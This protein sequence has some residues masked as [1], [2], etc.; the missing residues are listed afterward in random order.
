[1]TVQT[2]Y[3]YIAPAVAGQIVDMYFNEIVS[4]LVEDA[5]GLEFGIAV[6]RGTGDNQVLVA[7][8]FG[9]SVREL[10]REM[11]KRGAG[12]VTKYIEGNS[13]AI[14]RQGHIYV[15]LAGDAPVLAG[16]LLGYVAVTGVIVVL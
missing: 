6:G 7:G 2:E 1:M 12:A 10:T 8:T 13:A 15:T 5:T 11:D 9:V 16:G 4:K 3:A 14:M